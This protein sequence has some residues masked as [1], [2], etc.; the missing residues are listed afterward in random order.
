VVW[1]HRLTKLL[2]LGAPNRSESGLEGV[3]PKLS[4]RMVAAFA[5]KKEFVGCRGLI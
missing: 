1:N 2:T 3:R 5:E 4:S